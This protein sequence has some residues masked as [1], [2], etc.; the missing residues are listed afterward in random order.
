MCTTKSAVMFAT[1]Q[2]LSGL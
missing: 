1:D 2:W